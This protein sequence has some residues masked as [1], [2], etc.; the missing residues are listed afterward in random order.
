[1]QYPKKHSKSGQGLM[2]SSGLGSMKPKRRT[3][4][5]SSNASK[6]SMRGERD[7]LSRLFNL[8]PELLTKRSAYLVRPTS[9]GRRKTRSLILK[10]VRKYLQNTYSNLE[11]INALVSQ[12]KELQ[13]LGATKTLTASSSKRTR[14]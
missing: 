2:K 13:C 7:I 10:A 14:T 8:Y 5:R 3:P 1:M 9:T 12:D 6:T 4:K 11:H